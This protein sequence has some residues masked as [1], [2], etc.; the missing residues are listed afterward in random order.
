M[1]TI[2]M[3]TIRVQ[4]SVQFSGFGQVFK[5]ILSNGQEIAVKKLSKSSS[6]GFCIEE[7]EKLLVYEYVPNRSLDYFLFGSQNSRVLDWMER[8][9]GLVKLVSVSE[10]EGSTKRIVGTYG[11]MSPEYAMFGQYSEKSDVL[12]FGVIVLEIISRKKNTGCHDSQYADGLLSF[13]WKKWRDDKLVEML[14]SNINELGSYNEV[15]GKINC[16]AFIP[17][18]S[19]FFLHG[20]K[21]QPII[22]K[23]G[24]GESCSVNES[25]MSE[26]FPR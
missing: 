8:N 15:I 21:P 9:F 3:A 22:S 6:Q 14:D 10:S 4:L 1:D 19:A 26:F 24:S 20:H 2:R 7:Q 23:N 12:S 13:T 18:E 11:Y 16:L 17:Q 5:G 25:S